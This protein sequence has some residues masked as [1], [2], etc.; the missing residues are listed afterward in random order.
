M[1]ATGEM[2][3]VGSIPLVQAIAPAAQRSPKASDGDQQ[4]T[5]QRERTGSSL[6]IRSRRTGLFWQSENH[7]TDDV[8]LYL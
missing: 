2:E 7:L 4:Q 3:T 6:T 1:Q 8:S 5:Q